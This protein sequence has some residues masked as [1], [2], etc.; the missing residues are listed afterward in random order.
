VARAGDYEVLVHLS[1]ANV[2][3]CEAGSKAAMEAW[4][5]L[6]VACMLV[7]KYDDAIAAFERAAQL[8][9]AKLVAGLSDECRKESAALKARQP[10][11]PPAS[12]AEAVQTGII[13]TNDF[14]IRL[15][16]GNVAEQDVLKMIA[17]Q[18]GRFSLQPGDLARLK[19]AGVPDSVVAAMRNKK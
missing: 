8:N 13:M 16:D 7:G 19:A 12:Q 18:P 11:A 2:D 14:V 4:Y 1:R 3:S 15:I 17:N 6:G 5:N 10:K 9:G